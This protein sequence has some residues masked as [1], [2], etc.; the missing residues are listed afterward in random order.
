MRATLVITVALLASC[1]SSKTRTL[2]VTL[3]V[4]SGLQSEL[5][6][7]Y[8]PQAS[9]AHVTAIYPEASFTDVIVEG[10]AFDG[11]SEAYVLTLDLTNTSDK[12]V[13]VPDLWVRRPGALEGEPDLAFHARK[14]VLEPG[15]PVQLRYFWDP[16][17]AMDSVQA[18]LSWEP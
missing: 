14:R 13:P 12:T 11:L 15:K 1:G 6:V 3:Q 9:F 17:K 7:E 4:P 10:T 5:K 2:P 8:F 16:A 18:R